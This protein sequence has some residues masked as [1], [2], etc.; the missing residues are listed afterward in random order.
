MGIVI[1]QLPLGIGGDLRT[2]LIMSRAWTWSVLK[3][4]S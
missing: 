3:R 2:L 4:W 1:A